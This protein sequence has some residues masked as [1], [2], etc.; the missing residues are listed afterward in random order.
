MVNQF[1]AREVWFRGF[2]CTAKANWYI[3]RFQITIII[4]ILT[5]FKCLDLF[6]LF[7]FALCKWQEHLP[8]YSAQRNLN[9]ILG[10]SQTSASSQATAPPT[11]KLLSLPDK[12][13]VLTSQQDTVI[14]K[15]Q[16]WEPP[17]SEL[18]NQDTK[19]K[20]KH[21]KNQKAKVSHNVLSKFMIL[22][23]TQFTATLECAG[24]WS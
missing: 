6:L 15:I 19:Q 23:W 16:A 7:L 1:E 5:I 8:S 3:L 18:C 14:C 9:Q 12:S 21:K 13:N 4:T 17:G 22:Y 2:C 10:S 24:P 11:S 20:T